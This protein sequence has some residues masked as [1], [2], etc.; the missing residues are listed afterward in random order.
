MAKVN[1]QGIV[2]KLGSDMKAALRSAL[3]HVT[4][5][6]VDEG[7]LHRALARAIGRR[8]N[9]WVSVPD[10]CVQAKCPKCG[11]EF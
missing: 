5:N 3:G 7:E 1:L 11:T 4:E 8:M 6:D 2:E 10:T 9:T